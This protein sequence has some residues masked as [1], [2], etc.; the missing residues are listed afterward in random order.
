MH[1]LIAGCHS[2][3][4]FISSS[5]FVGDT[6]APLG[7]GCL[8]CPNLIFRGGPCF[9]PHQPSSLYEELSSIS[10]AHLWKLWLDDNFISMSICPYSPGESDVP[11]KVFS[12]HDQHHAGHGRSLVFGDCMRICSS[13]G[14]YL[15]TWRM[16]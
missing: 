7:G 5:S 2:A 14:D 4:R 12:C 13:D 9:T 8:H 3:I 16:T 6:A 10:K 15:R 1:W 11:V